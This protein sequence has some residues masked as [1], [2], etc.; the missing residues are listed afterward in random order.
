MVVYAKSSQIYTRP[1]EMPSV[2]GLKSYRVCR[3]PEARKRSSEKI[4]K[5]MKIGLKTPAPGAADM[6]ILLMK[7]SS[8]PEVRHCS[9]QAGPL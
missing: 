1:K 5:A 6:L 9:S 8:K 3:K 2:E 7:G 4:R